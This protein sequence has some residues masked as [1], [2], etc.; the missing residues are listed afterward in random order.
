MPRRRCAARRRP[1]K[2]WHPRLSAWLFL[3][4]WAHALD[5]IRSCLYA[6]GGRW[7]GA[8]HRPGTFSKSEAL[9]G[10]DEVL[11][12]HEHPDHMD[13]DQLSAAR[14][15]NSALRVYMPP[16]AVEK[17]LE[18]GAAAIAVEV[19]QRFTAIRLE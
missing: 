8:R 12:T 11:V 3:A 15:R 10:A 2:P 18:P 16:S 17:A 19:G 9:D 5:Q 14:E 7:P 6:F 4:W 1:W 13:L